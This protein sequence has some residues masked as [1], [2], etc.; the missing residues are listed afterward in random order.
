MSEQWKK[1]VIH[2][3]CAADSIHIYDVIKRNSELIEKCEKNEISYDEYLEQSS[4]KNRDIRIFGTAIFIIHN[5]KRYLL[6]ARHVL[7]DERSAYR[8]AQEDVTRYESFPQ[9]MR[10]SM[11][12]G[13]SERNLN[14]IFNII[15]RVPSLDEALTVKDFE[16]TTFL[17]NLGAG[18]SMTVPYTF[19]SPDLDLAL[20][21]LDRGGKDFAD[22]LI[23]RGYIPISSE[24]ISD[25]PSSEG[26]EIF[27]VGFPRATSLIAQINQH[28]ASAHWSSNYVSLPV[29]SWGRVSMLHSQLPFYWC[30]ISI[31]PGNSGGPVIENE[32]L[33]GIVSQQAILP[34]DDVPNVS[35]RIPFGKI[36]K[37]CFVKDLIKKQEAKDKLYAS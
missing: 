14:K 2:L 16:R 13:S 19:S 12:A 21:S 24:L 20:I 10:D 22:E 7:F 1:A 35:T 26:A 8:E 31:Y 18:N 9:D 36:I 27:S 4:I 30:D 3:E 5:K 33:V 25:G 32:K 28:P 17:M 37:T 6:T 11:L 15:F 29:F 34:I 23:A